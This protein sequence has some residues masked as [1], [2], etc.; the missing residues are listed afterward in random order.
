MSL[1]SRWGKS[2]VDTITS[3]V[4]GAFTRTVGTAIDVP[5]LRSVLEV[6]LRPIDGTAKLKSSTFVQIEAGKGSAEYP[7]EARKANDD[8]FVAL[9]LHKGIKDVA[10][11]ACSRVDAIRLALAGVFRHVQEYK[12]FTKEGGVNKDQ[13]VITLDSITNASYQQNPGALN[14][15]WPDEL[16]TEE[17]LMQERDSK[18]DDLQ[19]LMPNAEDFKIE[20]VYKKKMNTWRN[21]QQAVYD[22]YYQNLKILRETKKNRESLTATA[23]KL[24]TAIRSLY[25]AVAVHFI[26]DMPAEGTFRDSLIP[27]F[28]DMDFPAPTDRITMDMTE[29]GG[30][31]WANL[32][33]HYM[34]TAVATFLNNR[35]LQKKVN[36]YNFYMEIKSA[37]LSNHYESEDVWATTVESLVQELC[38]SEF[39]KELRKYKEWAA[40]TYLDSWLDP[41]VNRKRWAVGMKG[42][43]LLSDDSQKT[44]SFND[45][46]RIITTE[47][48]T[49]TNKSAKKMKEFLKS[50]GTN[51]E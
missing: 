29:D 38:S 22:Q 14:F 34:R 11:T 51:V 33:K 16:K 18:L 12:K 32:K 7:R 15:Q 6:V 41:L 31:I 3:G 43:I 28:N 4:R 27:V 37:M 46:G 48:A 26:S 24:S 10:E 39:K 5:L 23:Q 20:A 17:A 21:E 40:D 25:E 45:K 49:F 47:N 2:V 8:E 9:D 1:T 35:D 50:I 30:I 19:Q 13:S 42:K 36:A 44:I